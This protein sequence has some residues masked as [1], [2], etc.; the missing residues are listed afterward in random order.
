MKYLELRNKV[1]DF[2]K[3]PNTVKISRSPIV[4]NGFQGNFNV[5]FG[6]APLLKKFN[7]YL[8][9]SSS[10]NFSTIQQCIRLNDFKD[11]LDDSHLL[12][13]DMSDIAGFI[14]ETDVPDKERTQKAQFTIQKT[15]EFLIDEI[16]LDPKKFLI[17][18]YAGGEVSDATAGKYKFDEFI[19]KD[20]FIETVKK[21]GIS[22]E[23]F[24]PDRTRTTLLSL[25]FIPPAPWGY[26]N[27]ILYKADN[28]NEPLDIASIENLLWQ[29][30]YEDGRIVGLERWKNFCSFSVV[31]IERLLMLVNNFNKVY[32]A[33]HIMPLIIKLSKKTKNADFS[34]CRMM[35][36]LIRVFHRIIADVR[37]FSNLSA[38]R[39]EKL[40]PLRRKFLR[41]AL[42]LNFDYGNDLK[43]LLILN[44]KLQPCFPELLIDVDLQ[45]DEIIK[46]LQ[47]GKI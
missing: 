8:N 19:Q 25:N 4:H 14:Y 29:P 11:L 39:K 41:N 36:E 7:G 12:L 22:D 33:D 45:A 47:L 13:F 30:V 28:L 35:I 40:I 27:E 34:S 2:S 9:N 38:S 6:E 24:I 16:G 43:D 21:F 15:F 10:Y 3:Y 37:S 1:Q 17:S 23:Q 46:W 42:I 20:P 5:S 31:G 18:Y 26:R 32:E 44:G